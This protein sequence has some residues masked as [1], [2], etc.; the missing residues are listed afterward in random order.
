MADKK[1][2]KAQKKADRKKTVTLTKTTCFRD[3]SKKC[4]VRKISPNAARRKLKRKTAQDVSPKDKPLTQLVKSYQHGGS[5]GAGTL[6]GLVR[7]W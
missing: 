4:K 1:R 7:G 6:K 2:S 3:G 5:R